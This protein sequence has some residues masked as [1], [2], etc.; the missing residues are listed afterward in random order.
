MVL[1]KMNA[2]G[3]RGF[4]NELQ[5]EQEC[6]PDMWEEWDEA[7]LR[8]KCLPGDLLRVRVWREGAGEWCLNVCD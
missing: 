8:D 7:R 6:P 3:R 2:G 1:R 5:G 4:T